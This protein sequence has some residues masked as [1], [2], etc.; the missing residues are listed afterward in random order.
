MLPTL[1][2]LVPLISKIESRNAL[3]R[4]IT[5]IF[6]MALM[7]TQALAHHLDSS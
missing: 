6:S 3:P 4:Q 1:V 5:V 7:I 2:R